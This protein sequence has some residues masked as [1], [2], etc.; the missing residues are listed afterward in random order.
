MVGSRTE[1]C[2]AASAGRTQL[3][4]SWWGRGSEVRSARNAC[5]ISARVL[6][7]TL[8]HAA[9]CLPLAGSFEVPSPSRIMPS[10]LVRFAHKTDASQSCCISSSIFFC[11]V[12]SSSEG[13]SS[14]VSRN[15]YTR[16]L[17]FQYKSGTRHERPHPSKIIISFKSSVAWEQ[18]AHAHN[19]ARFLFDPPPRGSTSPESSSSSADSWSPL[20]WARH[21]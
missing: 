1:L 10:S 14:E 12:L 20:D 16:W 4:A 17:S 2:K 6:L 9:F 21:R 11:R 19:E 8:Q 7:P 15:P 18:P 13:K 3:W 5:K